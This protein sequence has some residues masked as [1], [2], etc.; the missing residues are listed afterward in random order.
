MIIKYP[1]SYRVKRLYI[2]LPIKKAV[3]LLSKDLS[4]WFTRDYPFFQM[5]KRGS[6]NINLLP[7]VA[8]H[9][10]SRQELSP[11]PPPPTLAT[12]NASFPSLISEL[13]GCSLKP[14]KKG[15]VWVG[16]KPALKFKGY[17][18]GSCLQ[19]W[20]LQKDGNTLL[21]GMRHVYT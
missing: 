17:S 1:L 7:R 12:P 5:R 6:E 3:F 15:L 9:T 11:K 18:T 20:C 4:G 14:R 16:P 10:K 13:S 8:W 2:Y 21:V 19:S